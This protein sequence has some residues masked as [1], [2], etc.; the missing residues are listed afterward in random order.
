MSFS[1]KCGRPATL[2]DTRTLDVHVSW[3]RKILEADPRHPKYLITIRNKGYRLDTGD[4]TEM[5]R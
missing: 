5:R 4:P 1:A 3:L 2:G